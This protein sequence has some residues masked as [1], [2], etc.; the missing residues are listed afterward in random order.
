MD[1]L[2]TICQKLMGSNKDKREGEKMIRQLAEADFD[3]Y[4]RLING[5][6]NSLETGIKIEG[7][8]EE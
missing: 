5:I 2:E 8:A 4:A 3:K 1:V 6:K 7:L